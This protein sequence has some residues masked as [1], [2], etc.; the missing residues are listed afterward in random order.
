VSTATAPD[1][2][3]PLLGAHQHFLLRR[4]HSLTGIVF[5][6]Y[7]IVHLLVNA[8]IAQFL[9]GDSAYRMSYQAQVDKIHSLPFLP[10]IEWTFIYLPIIFHTVYG[11]WITLT[12]QPNVANYP[13]ARNVFYVAQRISAIFI[14]VFML[15]HV[16]SFKY[17]LFGRQL[18]FNPHYGALQ[19]VATHMN[20]SFFITWVLYPLGI[21]ASCYH[22]A[23][24]FWTAAI[25]WGLTISK[26]SQRRWGCV[27]AGLFAI[28]FIA[29]M[30]AL[31]AS[32]RI[33]PADV[34]ATA[35]AST[36]TH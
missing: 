7:L 27:C 18:A 9:V 6:G 30:I 36:I 2:T 20:V 33:D 25:T 14:V 26:G 19:T 17:G 24:G 35:G 3:L 22:L 29:G 15:F 4:L 34:P 13:Y 10:V 21:L 11:I 12:G 16:L 28:T 8:T 23:N 1:Y 5:G 31:V 32:A